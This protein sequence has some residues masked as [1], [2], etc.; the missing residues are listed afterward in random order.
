MSTH[1]TITT[2]GPSPRTRKVA[3]LEA[4][5]ADLLAYP[6]DAAPYTEELRSVEAE[7]LELLAEG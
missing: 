7:L 2:I 1:L 5:R 6:V 3:E 4:V